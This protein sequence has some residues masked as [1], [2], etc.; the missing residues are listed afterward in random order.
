MSIARI[1]ILGLVGGGFLALALAFGAF[2]GNEP[3]GKPF[4]HLQGQIDGLQGEVGLIQGQVTDLQEQVD[5]VVDDVSDLQGQVDGL[6]DDVSSLEDRVGAAEESLQRQGTQVPGYPGVYEVHTK[7]LWSIG[8]LTNPAH[9]GGGYFLYHEVPKNLVYGPD[10]TTFLRPL[11]AYGIPEVQDGATRSVR[12][13]VNYGHQWMCGGTPTVRI[14]DVEFSL[15]EIHGFYGDMGAG[16][17]EFKDYSEYSHLDHA[18]IQ[19]YLKDFVWEGSHCNPPSRL[20]KGVM[21]RIE[22]HFYD[23]F[24]E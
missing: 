4:Q 3:Q 5:G 22:A 7:V 1:S 17:S 11:T 2:A 15:P 9:L 24:P 23:V 8:M 12:L 20:E 19:V 13:Y 6:L 18:G 10:R 21:Y 14:G 16:W